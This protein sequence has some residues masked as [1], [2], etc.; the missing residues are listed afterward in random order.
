MIHTDIKY[1]NILS[2]RL[3]KFQSKGDYL[4]QFRCPFCGDSKKNPNKAR[5][6]FYR[7]NNDMFY[8]CHNCGIGK[9]ASTFIKDF[10]PELHKEYVMERFR[11]GENGFSNYQKP[12]FKFEQP[13]FN[14][15]ELNDYIT[16][17]DII[18]INKLDNSHVAKKYLLSRKIPNLDEL[19]Y[20]DDFKAFVDKLLPN[21]YDTLASEGRIII[22]FYD[23]SKNLV[24][25]QGRNLSGNGLRYITIKIKEDSPKI[26]GMDKVDTNER[27]YILEGPFD[28]MFLPNSIGMA[29]SDLTDTTNIFH[30]GMTFIYDNERRNREIVSKMEEI[31]ESGHDIFIW[32]DTIEKKDINEIFLL[33]MNTKE[34]LKMINR[35][36]H[37]GLSA[38]IAINH[39]KR[40]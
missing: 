28:S 31:I 5:G 14:T 36:T 8:K 40:C 1:I 9:T 29:G 23:R 24:A 17:G 12:K 39:W 25:L 20:T 26:Y 6:F 16:T 18:P 37:N 33:G 27:V 7:K 4:F 10:D 35:N 15:N 22:P 32:P 21:K 11:S 38:K 13:V 34:I 3:N 19:Y 2:A 30:S